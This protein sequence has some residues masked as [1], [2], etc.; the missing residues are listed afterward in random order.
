MKNCY[1][2]LPEALAIGGV[3]IGVG[4]AFQGWPAWPKA[5]GQTWAA[6][7]QAVGS[8]IAILA[9]VWISHRDNENAKK[10][11]LAAER[12]EATALLKMIEAELSVQWKQY[13]MSAGA[14]ILKIQADQPFL[15]YWEPPA[16][17]FTVQSAAV[18]RLIAVDDA[19]LRQMIILAYAEFTLLLRQ[20]G[21]NNREIGN[22]DQTNRMLIQGVEAA[23]RLQEESLR[24]M[25]NIARS[26]KN[27][28]A[29]AEKYVG[30]ARSAI[31]KYLE[32]HA[33]S[34]V[35]P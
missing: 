26:L 15:S 13:S 19:E 35:R 21:V 34:N 16:V 20:F 24:R 11:A 30:D 3:A 6:W 27:A 28:H 8:I 32:A 1:S 14:L 2:W 18:G 33:P 29:R 9:A 12:S 10:R 4:V 25:S 17:P 23:E 31:S 5:E 22:I 7:V